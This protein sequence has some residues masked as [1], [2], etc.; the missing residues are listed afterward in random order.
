[1]LPDVEEDIDSNQIL[2]T[3]TGISGKADNIY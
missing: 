3:E 1:M 2:M